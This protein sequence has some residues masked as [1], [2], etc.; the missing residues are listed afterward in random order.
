VAIELADVR[1]TYPSRTRSALDGVSLR[2]AT[3]STVAVV[4]PSGA[5]KTTIAS[6]LLRFWDP[7]HGVVRLF[8]HDLRDYGLDDLRRRIALVAQ[9]TYLFHDTLRANIVLA[10]PEATDAEVRLA[11]ERAA[12]AELVD[13]LPDGLATVVGERGARLSGGSASAWPSPARS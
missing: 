10:R 11:V 9:D 5:G 7:Q 1:F 6:L 8:G 3:G 12:L 4:G 13:S 2:I